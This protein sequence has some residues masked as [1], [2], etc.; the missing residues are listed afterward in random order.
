MTIEEKK[1]KRSRRRSLRPKLREEGWQSLWK[2]L[3]IKRI[4]KSLNKDKG[5]NKQ[6]RL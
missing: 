5:T 3:K 2:I 6:L 4:M 1:K